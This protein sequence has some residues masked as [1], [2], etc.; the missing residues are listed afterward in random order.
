MNMKYEISQR[1]G[2]PEWSGVENS[3]RPGPRRL[4]ILAISAD[5]FAQFMHNFFIATEAAA[6]ADKK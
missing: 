3:G 5:T 4:T 1:T 6:G 2:G